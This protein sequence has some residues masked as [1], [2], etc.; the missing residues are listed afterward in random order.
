MRLDSYTGVIKSKSKLHRRV[1]Y[2]FIVKET[3]CQRKKCIVK[4]IQWEPT[5]KILLQEICAS[6]ESLMKRW[7]L[8][9][10]SVTFLKLLKH[11]KLTKNSITALR[12]L[13]LLILKKGL[14]HFPTTFKVINVEKGLHHFLTTLKIVNTVLK[15]LIQKRTPSL[16]YDS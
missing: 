5:E 2:P 13:E 11:L 6:Y 4:K 14:R 9:N 1:Y 3:Y 7:P 10:D 8:K 15:F 16:S 12:L